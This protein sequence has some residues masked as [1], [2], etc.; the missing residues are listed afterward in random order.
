MTSLLQLTHSPGVVASI[1]AASIL[2]FLPAHPSTFDYVVVAAFAAVAF[3]HCVL[4]LL[5]ELDD[6]RED[7]QKR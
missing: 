5:R 4:A 3:G 1:A 2:V 6:Y 7:R